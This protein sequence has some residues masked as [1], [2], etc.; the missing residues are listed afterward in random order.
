MPIYMDRHDVSVEVTAEIVAQ[1]HQAD[2][3]VQDDYNCKGITY[4]FDDKRKTAFCL[5]EAPNKEAIKQ[6]HNHSHGAVPH[7][8]IEVDYNL[9]ASFLGRIEDPVKAQNTALNI[10]NDPA[11]RTIM[12]IAIKSSSIKTSKSLQPHYQK[13]NTAIQTYLTQYNGRI[14]KQRPYCFLVAFDSVSQAVSCALAIHNKLHKPTALILNIG[15][16]AGVPVTEKKGIFAGTI[17]MAERLCEYSTRPVALSAEVKDLYESEHFSLPINKEIYAL[18]TTEEKFLNSL[19]DYTEQV[20]DNTTV[21]A[22]DFSETLGYS[23]SQLYRKMVAIL[24]KSPNTFL[25]D[26]R[27]TKALALLDKQVDNI[28]EVAFKTGFNS[29]AYFSKCFMDKYGILPSKY[30]QQYLNS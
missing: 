18:H 5:I 28:S 30:I 3:K 8:I 4:W 9:V 24:G 13:L 21:S 7:Q 20:W 1:L 17:K 19:L 10:I 26:Y 25:K 16:S 11:F 2:L 15:L 23:K 27:L 22:V 29:P 14:V 6:M 12:V